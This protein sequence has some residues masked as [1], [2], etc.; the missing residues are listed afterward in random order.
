[1]CCSRLQDGKAQVAPQ[2]L[3]LK[4]LPGQVA[5]GLAGGDRELVLAY[6]R[7]LLAQR[8]VDFDNLVLYVRALFDESDEVRQRWSRKFY[9]LQVDEMQDTNLA[10]YYVVRVLARG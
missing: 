3:D 5:E 4:R 1:A 9:M 6:E 10:E 8:A 2:R 7:E